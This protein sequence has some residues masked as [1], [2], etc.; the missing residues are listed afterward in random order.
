MLHEQLQKDEAKIVI[1]GTIPGDKAVEFASD[2]DIT[3]IEKND[4]SN[5]LFD[6]DLYVWKLLLYKPE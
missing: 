4:L 6:D 5:N 2:G 1:N 3:G